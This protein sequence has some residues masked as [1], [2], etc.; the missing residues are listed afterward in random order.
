MTTTMYMPVVYDRWERGTT[1]AVREIQPTPE[2]AM[3]LLNRELAGTTFDLEWTHV[4]SCGMWEAS[5]GE[6][7]YEVIEVQVNLT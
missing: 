4:A 5:R 7:M 2:L 6:L 1:P 3:D